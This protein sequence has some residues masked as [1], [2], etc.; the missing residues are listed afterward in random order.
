MTSATL[1]PRRLLLAAV[2]LFLV[3]LP[4]A[5]SQDALKLTVL[6]RYI[7][8]DLQNVSGALTLGRDGN[9][10]GTTSAGG[11][12][13]G[14]SVFR[15]TLDGTLT[16]LHSFD[17][18]NG[19]RTANYS[20]LLEDRNTPGVFYGTSSDFGDFE[21]GIAFQITADGMFTVLHS[22]NGDDGSLPNTPLAQG[23]EATST[24]PLLAAPLAPMGSF[25]SSARREPSRSCTASTSKMGSCPT[26]RWWRAATASSTAPPSSTTARCSGSRR[27][28]ISPTFAV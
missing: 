5:R 10:Y 24:A 11:A 13:G 18:P 23:R 19:N 25:T 2:C 26:P 17:L 6:H 22:F 28:A 1:H 4:A 27:R 15:I 16:V 14:G 3:L 7:G 9:L 21:F 8:S 12:N 20:T